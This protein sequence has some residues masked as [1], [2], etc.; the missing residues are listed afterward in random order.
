[1]YMERVKQVLAANFFGTGFKKLWYHCNAQMLQFR[2]FKCWELVEEDCCLCSDKYFQIISFFLIFFYRLKKNI[3]LDNSCMS[4]P[5]VCY[6][7]N[8][9]YT[10]L[11]QTLEWESLIQQVPV[12][13]QL[14]LMN[15]FIYLARSVSFGSSIGWHSLHGFQYMKRIFFQI[16]SYYIFKFV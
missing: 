7:I 6:P 8:W 1:M 15:K 3:L 13:Q 16:L 5:H 4:H 9:S 14:A 11:K 2:W 10:E 12:V